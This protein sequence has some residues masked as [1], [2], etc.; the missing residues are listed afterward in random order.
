MSERWAFDAFF[1]YILCVAA[2]LDSFAQCEVTELSTET[3]YTWSRL[4]FGSS[5]ACQSRVTVRH[6]S[7]GGSEVAVRHVSHGW[8]RGGSEVAVRHVSHRWQWG[9]SATGGSEVAVRHVSHGWQW[10]GS[11]ACQP[12][13][14]VRWQWGMSA[15]VGSEACAL[16]K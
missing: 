1:C 2:R 8:Q 15:T 3:F 5:K 14:A 12:L 11:E 13:V 9:I 7:K 6:V 16:L 10:G 4:Q